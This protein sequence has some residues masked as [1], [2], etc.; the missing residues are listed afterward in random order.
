M[1][2]LLL[3]SLLFG[4]FAIANQLDSFLANQGL[5]NSESANFKS[6]LGQLA[7]S[8]FSGN[9]GKLGIYQELSLG[10]CID[11]VENAKNKQFESG[12]SFIKSAHL[13]GAISKHTIRGDYQQHYSPRHKSDSFGNNFLRGLN[14]RVH[15]GINSHN[16]IEDSPQSDY[17]CNRYMDVVRVEKVEIEKQTCRKVTMQI[18]AREVK[19][20]NLIQHQFANYFCLG[21][22]DI[23][24]DYLGKEAGTE[25]RIISEYQEKEDTCNCE[26]E[27]DHSI[28][29]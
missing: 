19:T 11:A 6:G 18:Q 24:T 3:M 28:L 21:A 12:K 20:D 16:G 14:D 17:S 29:D 10:A 9:K 7:S 5:S 13:I 2:K 8:L 25:E 27:Y 22:T 23:K 26:P 4:N 1:K 15:L